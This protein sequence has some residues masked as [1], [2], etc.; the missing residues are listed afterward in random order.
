MSPQNQVLFA[1]KK[2]FTAINKFKSHPSIL[3]INK[4]M[5]RIG[6]HSFHFEFITLK[7]TI[8][9]VNKVLKNS[10]TRYNC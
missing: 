10:D 3:S 1:L 2:V 5:E 6:C 8:K 4:N 7:E 9:E